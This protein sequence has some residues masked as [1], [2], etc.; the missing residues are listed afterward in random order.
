MHIDM[1]DSE[2]LVA[3]TA[4]RLLDYASRE[5]IRAELLKRNIDRNHADRIIAQAEQENRRQRLR[6]GAKH[7]MIAVVCMMLGGLIMSNTWHDGSYVVPIGL[8]CFGLGFAIS[9]ITRL[10]AAVTGVK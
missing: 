9:G 10:V 4:S 5:S 6:A 1:T 8:L 3:Y 7:L 2:T